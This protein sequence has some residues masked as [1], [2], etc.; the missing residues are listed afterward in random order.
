MPVVVE[1]LDAIPLAGVGETALHPAE[2]GEAGAQ[3]V[4]A[5]K[6][7]RIL[8]EKPGQI[9]GN[10]WTA[11]RTAVFEFEIGHAFYVLP[12][13]ICPTCALHQE[14]QIVENGQIVDV[15]PIAARDRRLT[16]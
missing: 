4:A 14:A 7:D 6:V 1:D 13:H 16:V 11:W 3:S 2:I 15:W 8:G 5:H 12:T 10:F 9:L